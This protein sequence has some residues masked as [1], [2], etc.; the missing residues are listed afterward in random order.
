MRITRFAAQFAIASSILLLTA[1]AGAIG[2]APESDPTQSSPPVAVV[3]MTDPERISAAEGA[4]EKSLPDAPIWVGMT[5]KGVVV[6][7]DEVCV[8][9][10]WAPGGGP[11]DKGG[12]AGYVVVW[13]PAETLGEP[14]E[15]FCVDYTV[16][17]PVSPVEV[18]AGVADDPDLVVSS[19][20]GDE[21]PLTVPYAVVHCE[22][23][24]AGGRVLQV[25][26]LTAPDG[27]TYA[28][29]GTAKDHGN[30]ADIDP[31]WAPDPD[32]DSLKIDISPIIEAALKGC[33]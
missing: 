13:F 23:I 3:T 11:E 1:C 17:E 20:Y 19:D 25:A 8:D 28:A 16:A 15:G 29:N 12:N 26:S 9:R 10:T 5:F 4:V 24:V 21:W 7:A 32:V 6:D 2:P 33:V 30:F 27:T 14:Q 18:P 31:I 22:E